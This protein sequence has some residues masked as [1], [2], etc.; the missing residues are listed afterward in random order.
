VL[1]WLCVPDYIRDVV[2]PEVTAGRE[3]AGLTMEGF[4]IVPA[5]PSGLTDDSQEAYRRMRSE[6]VPYWSLP[7]Y[8]TMIQR[9]GFGE[10]IAAFDAAAG[11]VEAMK[12]AIPDTFLESLA[13]VGDAD[14]VR[15]GIARYN[16]AG[17]DSPLVAPVP[18]TDFAATL[19]AAAP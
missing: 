9:A 14:A 7:F 4:S 5:V 17:A 18:G 13:A 12:S 11:N 2:V 15:A 3:R 16:A 8:R 10:E 19:R 6:L 1:L